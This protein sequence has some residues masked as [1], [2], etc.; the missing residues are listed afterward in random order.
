[1]RIHDEPR[2]VNEVPAV[3]AEVQEAALKIVRDLRGGGRSGKVLEEGDAEV[4]RAYGFTEQEIQDELPYSLFQQLSIRVDESLPQM[5]QDRPAA[6]GSSM[7]DFFSPEARAKL[8]GVDEERG[9]APVPVPEPEVRPEQPSVSAELEERARHVL[10]AVRSGGRIE[11]THDTAEVL[12]AYGFSDDEIAQEEPFYLLQQLQKKVGNVQGVEPAPISEQPQASEPEPPY[13]AEQFQPFEFSPEPATQVKPEQPVDPLAELVKLGL[14][15]AAVEQVPRFG[16]LT[17]GQQLLVL[18]NFKQVHLGE[19]HAA[20]RKRAA[21]TGEAKAAA[22]KTK[23]GKVVSRVWRAV[24]TFSGEPSGI[25]ICAYFSADFFGRVLSMTP[26]RIGH[27]A[28]C[29]IST[30]RGLLRNCLR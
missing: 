6:H 21:E 13:V 17:R 1:M 11:V 10:A 30:T 19:V 8:L 18:E 9:A 16:E 22:A 27:H 24:W 23:V 25:Q 5:H 20:G 2:G 15:R 12:R 26:F 28:H 29:G 4:L 14:P 7:G 3:S